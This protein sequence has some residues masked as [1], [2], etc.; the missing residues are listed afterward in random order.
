MYTIGQVSK[1]FSIPISTLR[2]YDKEGLFTN[3]QRES[4]IRRFSEAELEALRVIDCLKKSGLEIR[5][6]KQFMEWTVEGGKTYEKRLNLL[7]CQRNTIEAEIERLRRALDMI[8]YKCWYYEQ[9]I[10]D[11]SDER[12][13]SLSPD[14]MPPEIAQYYINAHKDN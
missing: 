1:M 13:R 11:G 6:I 5:D 2:Y 10:A 9:A 8:N 14:E 7:L 3:M 4:G 12:V